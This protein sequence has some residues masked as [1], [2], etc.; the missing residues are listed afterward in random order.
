[1]CKDGREDFAKLLTERLKWLSKT[2]GRNHPQVLQASLLVKE[3]LKETII[4][5][6]ITST[7]IMKAQVMAVDSIKEH[8]KV[9]ER[10]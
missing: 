2:N 7:G 3:F 10:S 9:R 4:E 5:T 1:M 6:P 8:S